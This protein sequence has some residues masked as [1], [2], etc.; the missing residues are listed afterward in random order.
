MSVTMSQLAKIESS[1]KSNPD[2][3]S[4]WRH[5]ETNFTD[6]LKKYEPPSDPGLRR[7]YVF[8][9]R[10]N[11]LCIVDIGI[12]PKSGLYVANELNVF[13]DDLLKDLPKAVITER[14][15]SDRLYFEDKG[16]LTFG[17]MTF[18]DVVGRK[19][20]RIATT[21]TEEDALH[22]DLRQYAGKEILHEENVN[23]ERCVN[24]SVYPDS[25]IARA[26]KKF[27][28]SFCHRWLG[29]DELRRDDHHIDLD[30]LKTHLEKTNPKAIP[31]LKSKNPTLTE[32][33][34]GRKVVEISAVATR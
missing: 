34:F 16:Y 19:D 20:V 17:K 27:E 33:I 32:R 3:E 15:R 7:W 6:S 21:I 30:I 24:V 13:I 9:E 1:L 14:C 26:A 29:H 22:P 31:Y 10:S 4:V 11:T 2:V 5:E 18:E 8:G 12:A 23:V 25:Q 28:F